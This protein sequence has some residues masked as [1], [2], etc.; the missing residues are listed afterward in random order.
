MR[1]I[2]ILILLAIIFNINQIW[3]NATTELEM[4][5]N[6]INNFKANFTQ[7]II[8][9]NGDIIQKS[10]GQLWIKRPNLFSWHMISPDENWLISNGNNIWFYNPLIK[11]VTITLLNKII[12]DTPFILI[13]H[14]N[15]KDWKKYKITQNGNY[16]LLTKIKNKD[17]LKYF[18]IIINNDGNIIQFTI[19]EKNGQINKYYIKKQQNN[20]IDNNKFKFII[21]QG[22]TIDDQR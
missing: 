18:S 4:R 15:P 2:I 22:V 3:A 8:D 14:N 16:F 21:P 9:I 1:K 13:T 10:K 7:K 19:V 5:L 6:K 20:K 17:N 11:Q 12:T